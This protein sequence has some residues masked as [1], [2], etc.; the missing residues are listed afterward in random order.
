MSLYAM[1]LGQS[2]VGLGLTILQCRRLRGDTHV[3][4]DGFNTNNVLTQYKL[5][6]IINEVFDKNII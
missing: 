6:L 4:T 2:L 3:K 1:L 5:I